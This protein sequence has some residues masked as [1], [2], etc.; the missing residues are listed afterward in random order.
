MKLAP[1]DPT[2]GCKAVE[3]YVVTAGGDGWMSIL[4]E[5]LSAARATFVD[6]F[7]PG[8]SEEKAALCEYFDDEDN[9]T[10]YIG[11]NGPWREELKWGDCD[12]VRVSR[13]LYSALK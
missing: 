3:M 11:P 6:M 1:T 10:W 7:S 5:G 12:W 13:V 4:V 8:D 2:E 9:W